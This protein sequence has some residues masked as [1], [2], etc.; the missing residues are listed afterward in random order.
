MVIANFF[1]PKSTWPGR[2]LQLPELSKRGP[3]STVSSKLVKKPEHGILRK[4]V[5]LRNH[6]VA[7]ES[8]FSVPFTENTYCVYLIVCSSYPTSAAI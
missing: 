1:T 3:N 6:L 8:N 5:N 2:M 4:I 7:N